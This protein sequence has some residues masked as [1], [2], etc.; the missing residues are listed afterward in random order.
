MPGL[1]TCNNCMD[2]GYV[3]WD[4]VARGCTCDT[5]RA[6]EENRRKNMRGSA[7]NGEGREL[8]PPGGDVLLSQ[9]RRE[10]VGLPIG[11]LEERLP[12]RGV[13][14]A[15]AMEQANLAVD[16]ARAVAV[17]LSSALAAMLAD[18]GEG[19]PTQTL[20]ERWT[21]ATQGLPEWAAPAIVRAG[22][23]RTR[24]ASAAAAPLTPQ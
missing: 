10:A 18:I 5:G 8:L 7:G 2:V 4:G 9:A 13:V 6:W 12:V 15:D 22:N 11:A 14:T 23:A 17:Q 16:E 24:K 1:I 3:L 20:L 19:V 21:P